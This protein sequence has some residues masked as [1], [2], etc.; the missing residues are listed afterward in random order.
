M[1]LM[2]SMGLYWTPVTVVSISLPDWSLTYIK[3]YNTVMMGLQSCKEYSGAFQKF[4]SNEFGFLGEPGH[5]NRWHIWIEVN[6]KEKGISC[7]EALRSGLLYSYFHEHYGKIIDE[8]YFS[9]EREFFIEHVP[10]KKTNGLR[11][12]LLIIATMAMAMA[13]AIKTSGIRSAIDTAS[14]RQA[15]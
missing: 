14:S 12:I 8:K 1:A 2:V 13:I 9:L 10:L 6:N 5:N 4:E 7:L 11:Y 15:I 3:D